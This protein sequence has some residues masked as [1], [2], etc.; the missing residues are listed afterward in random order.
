VET[1]IKALGVKVLESVKLDS[2][3]ASEYASFRVPVP[4]GSSDKF[5]DASLWPN[6]VRI[7]KFL[8]RR[9][10]EEK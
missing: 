10:V 1:Y 2:R 8:F 3:R 4:L 9:P 7:R 5:K 6:S